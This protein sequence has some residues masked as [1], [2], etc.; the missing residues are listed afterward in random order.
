MKLSTPVL[1]A[2]VA[3]ALL[4]NVAHACSACGCTLSSD[5]DSE[6]Y[7]RAAGWR[8]DLRQDFVHQNRLRSGTDFVDRDGIAT[9]ADRE[10]EL[11][12]INRYSTVG[13]DYSPNSDWSFSLQLPF[14]DRPHWTI[15]EGETESSYST[16]QGLGDIR[17]LARYQGF[18]KSRN[19]G[20]TAGLKLPTGA[21]DA[22]FKKGSEAGEPLDRG[23]QLGSG[24]TDLLLGA[25]RFGNLGQDWDWF[26]Q[27]QAQVAVA[28][29]DHY[30]PGNALNL[31]AGLRWLGNAHFA[32]QLQINGRVSARDSGFEADAANSGGS[33]L[34]L[35]PGASMP[36]GE[37]LH[38][39]GFVQV[40]V[41]QR[42]NGLQL[43]PRM[44]VSLGARYDF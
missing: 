10:I 24:S 4:P 39:Y 1:A 23:L 7:S 8:I 37:K 33:S 27:G 5:W 43:V 42:V 40:P 3:C 34:Y 44:N 21:H 20:V 13:I 17:L 29:A 15:P 12:T 18:S 9:P 30:R 25:Y 19:F 36:I 14:T 22:T 2:V 31:N 41:Y 38:L 32:P 16:V 35:S 28:T 26:V 11:A 6:S